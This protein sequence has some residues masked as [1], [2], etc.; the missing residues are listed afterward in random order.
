MKLGS[1]VRLFLIILSLSQF[2]YLAA[3]DSPHAYLVYSWGDVTIDGV[4]IGTTGKATLDGKVVEQGMQAIFMGQNVTTSEGEA[5]VV[6]QGGAA[7]IGRESVARMIEGGIELDHGLATMFIEF[8]R[9]VRSGDI[10]IKPKLTKH[11]SFSVQNLD[12]NLVIRAEVGDLIIQ[13]C[14]GETTLLQGQEGR[15]SESR[16]CRKVGA[17]PG[18]VKPLLDTKTA[19]AAGAIGGGILIWKVWPRPETPASVSSPSLRDTR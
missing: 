11:T 17:K 5:K 14:A 4:P 18:V 1:I 3:Q 9:F 12:G 10:L 6:M 7:V 8:G 2:S 15:R 13:D 19:I 16:R